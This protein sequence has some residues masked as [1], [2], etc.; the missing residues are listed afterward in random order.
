MEIR[1]E[2]DLIVIG[3][4]AAGFF[5][6]INYA[7]LAKAPKK[8]LILESGTQFLRKV[9]ISGGGRC[10]VTTS[11]TDPKE[12]IKNYPRGG[13]S[14]L[15]GFYEFG[16]QQM[17]LWLENKKVKLKTENDGRIFPI[18]NSSQTII[19]KFYE[20]T[21]R[22]NIQKITRAKVVRVKKD[23]DMFEI[24]CQNE[25]TFL[26]K[27]LLISTG[28]STAGFELIKQ[29][30]HQVTPLV[31]SLFTFNLKNNPYTE[32][33]GVSLQNATVDLHAGKYK[34]SETGPLLMT[35]KGLSGPVIL[36]IS[37]VAARELKQSNYHAK[38]RIRPFMD[39][40]EKEIRDELNRLKR[41]SPEKMPSNLPIFGLPK[42]LWKFYLE[43][44]DFNYTNYKS[45]QEKGINRLIE[46][47]QNRFDEIIGKNT[48]K[49][50]FVTCG[51]VDLKQVD[52]KTFESNLINRLFFAGEVLD[53]DAV[54]GGFN[55]QNAW[56]SSF[57]AARK[58]ASKEG[59]EA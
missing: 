38:I 6:A 42:K 43:T 56:T 4:G 44:A 17:V 32:L 36:K 28:S 37:S 8:I 11:I 15:Y 33:S 52:L 16:P 1:E 26:S 59:S 21:D 12:L 18:T 41:E 50:E 19:D 40:K 9:K 31:P 35:H 34:L 45:I 23:E 13:R 25:T 2:Y 57:L 53:V 46:T 10:N 14:L 39:K 5:G 55:F 48:F 49:E 22:Y 3:G 27:H 47:I 51:G 54:T 58:M 30:G 29:F 20:L 7:E 24:K